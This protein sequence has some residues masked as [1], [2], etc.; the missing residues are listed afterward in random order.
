MGGNDKNNNHNLSGDML[1][2]FPMPFI[3]LLNKMLNLNSK[4][5]LLE[6]TVRS[7]ILCLEYMKPE[8]LMSLKI[9]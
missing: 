4:M 8:S 3:D 9:L 1:I 7:V 5:S 2:F 6:V